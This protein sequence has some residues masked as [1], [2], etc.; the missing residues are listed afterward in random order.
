MI[1][2]DRLGFGCE[3]EGWYTEVTNY[4]HI[5]GRRA[6]RGRDLDTPEIT[7]KFVQSIFISSRNSDNKLDLTV[8][9]CTSC[10]AVIRSVYSFSAERVTVKQRFHVRLS[11]PEVNSR[12]MHA[13]Y[14]K[15]LLGTIVQTNYAEK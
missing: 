10:D 6:H 13:L 3:A 11:E 7:I 9:L 1:S 15:T 8:G 5:G 2:E 14:N 12:S 4:E